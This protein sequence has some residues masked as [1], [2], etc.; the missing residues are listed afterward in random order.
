M[1]QKRALTTLL[2][3]ADLLKMLEDLTNPSLN[4]HLSTGAF[5]G[6][7]ITLRNVRD[8]V[9]TA[10][11]VLLASAESGRSEF[12]NRAAEFG[13]NDSVQERTIRRP[14]HQ[15]VSREELPQSGEGI[16][17]VTKTN[18]GFASHHAQSVRRS[19]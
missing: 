10:H 14:L 15:E 2:E 12:T 18:S 5:G 8:A 11:E 13:R 4:P 16:E 3:S 6:V 1:D 9:V 7:R 17:F 19:S